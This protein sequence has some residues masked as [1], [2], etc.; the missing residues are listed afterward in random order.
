[1]LK[2]SDKITIVDNLSAD[3]KSMDGFALVT[4][5]GM[6]VAAT[7]KLKQELRA[8]GAVAQVYKNRLLKLALHNNEISGLD[9]YLKNSTMFI[10]SKT[11]FMAALKTL[12]KFAKDNEQIA[13]KGGV[14]AGDAYGDQQIIEISKL[15]GQKE[16]IA[17]IA[18]AMN[19]VVGK[20]AGVLNAILTKFVGTIEAVEKKNA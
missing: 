13:L 3:L 12:V 9:P 1:M 2:K 18:G 16:L 11:D 5:K 17:M 8:I 7:M 4:F 6:T 10:G 14:V 20:F 15:P 19:G